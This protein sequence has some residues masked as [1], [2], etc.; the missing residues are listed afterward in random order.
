MAFLTPRFGGS[1]NE[2]PGRFLGRFGCQTD[3]DPIGTL[4]EHIALLGIDFARLG[5]NRYGLHGH[6]SSEDKKA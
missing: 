2:P 5:K 3:G 1:V 6:S 4:D